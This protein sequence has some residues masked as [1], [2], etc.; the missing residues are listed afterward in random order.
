MKRMAQG[1]RQVHPHSSGRWSSHLRHWIQLLH[2]L[3]ASA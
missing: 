2:F 3:L 1:F